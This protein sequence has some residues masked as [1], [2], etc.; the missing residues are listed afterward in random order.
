MCLLEFN[1]TANANEMQKFQQFPNIARSQRQVLQYYF[2]QKRFQEKQVILKKP[3]I[4]S[5]SSF[6]TTQKTRP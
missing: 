6:L 1:W 2:H 4:W 3:I 5:D